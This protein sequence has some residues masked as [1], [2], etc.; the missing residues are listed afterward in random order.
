MVAKLQSSRRI[1]YLIGEV[2]LKCVIN[3]RHRYR[4]R[5]M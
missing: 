2:S 5:L 3:E 4:T 1:I